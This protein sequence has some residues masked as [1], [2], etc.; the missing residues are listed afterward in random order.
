MAEITVIEDGRWGYKNVNVKCRKK[1][2]STCYKRYRRTFLFNHFRQIK[3]ILFIHVYLRYYSLWNINIIL[4]AY[5]TIEIFKRI[6][7]FCIHTFTDERSNYAWLGPTAS[8]N[9]V[10]NIFLFH[11]L[12]HILRFSFACVY[13]FTVHAIRGTL[14]HVLRQCKLHL[15]IRNNI[16]LTAFQTNISLQNKLNRN[17]KGK[18]LKTYLD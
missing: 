10:T 16:Y 8:C 7:H 17:R 2:N 9:D 13:N 3:K 12:P 14:H 4:I 1:L 18:L 15:R 11:L 6:I 5:Q